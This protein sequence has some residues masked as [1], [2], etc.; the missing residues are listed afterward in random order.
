MPS[1]EVHFHTSL[2]HVAIVMPSIVGDELA[3]APY[4]AARTGFKIATL[5][6][7][8]DESTNDLPRPTQLVTLVKLITD[9]YVA[10][11]QFFL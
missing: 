3:Q 1:S 2:A 8:G 5:R 9:L 10:N 6:M 4:V 7:K 11:Y